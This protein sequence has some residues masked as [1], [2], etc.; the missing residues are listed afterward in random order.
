M[1][2]AWPQL[3]LDAWRDTRDTLHMWT[4]IVGKIA[5]ATTPHLNHFWNV[6]LQVTSRGLTTYPLHAENRVFSLAFDFID[7]QL[8]ISCSDGGSAA[9]P[10]EP[11]S[12]A[13][14]YRDLMAKL[15]ALGLGVRIWPVPVEIEQPIPFERDDVHHSYDRARVEDFHLA[16]TAMT[17]IFQAFRARFLGKSSPVHFFWGSFDLASTR[18]SGRRAPDRPGADPITREAYSHE[19]ISHG[20]WPGGGAV[21]DGAFY[22]Y[23]APEPDGFRSARVRPEE[24]AYHQALSEFILPYD[25]VRRSA[26]PEAA[27]AAFLETTYEAAADLAHWNRHELER[28]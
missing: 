10:L 1:S 14:F 23:A 15:A 2:H 8:L 25:A 24:A 11:R 28:S 12:V 13:S 3:P 16:L 20:Y 19:V 18:F 22:A 27:L 17:P 21:S 9:L 4:Q 5:L 6:A 26:S 7:H